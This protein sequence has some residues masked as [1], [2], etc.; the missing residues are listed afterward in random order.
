MNNDRDELIKT[1]TSDLIEQLGFSGTVE[2]VPPI[3]EQSPFVCSVQVSE[4]QNFLIGQYGMNLAA[5]QHLVRIL[6]RKRLEEKLDIIVDINDYFSEKKQLL[7]KEAAHAL[8][9]ALQKNMTVVL[10]PMLPYE[11]KIIHSF[12]ST[13]TSVETES[14]G[15]GAERK[16][17]VR[18]LPLAST[19]ESL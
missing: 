1:L 13:N 15:V 16:V 12:L 11:R 3:D 9:E 18:P 2:V 17:M 14:V 7:E 6:V 10:R 19:G 4:G 8:E 5:I